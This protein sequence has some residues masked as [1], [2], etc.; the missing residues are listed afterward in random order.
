MVKSFLTENLFFDNKNYPYGFAR[1]GDFTIKEARIL[2]LYGFAFN[3][4]NLSKREPINEEERL[5]IEV[6]K[7]LREP[8]TEAEH[9]W[10]KY[11]AFIKRPKRFHTLSGG[12][13]QS[14]NHLDDYNDSDLDD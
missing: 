11:I 13:I 14:D 10:L 6:C 1:H 5:F 4:L 7:G 12:Y 2:E 3:E 9:V 8:R